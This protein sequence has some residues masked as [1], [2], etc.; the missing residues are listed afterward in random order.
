MQGRF[1]IESVA[2]IFDNQTNVRG[3]MVLNFQNNTDGT[4]LSVPAYVGQRF[5][6]HAVQ[7][8]FDLGR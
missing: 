2:I 6:H 7:R 5:L 3:V 1:S 8:D 4:R